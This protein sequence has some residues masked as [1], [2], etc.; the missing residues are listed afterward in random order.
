MI[1]IEDNCVI[2]IDGKIAFYFYGEAQSLSLYRDN[3][4]GPLIHIGY[5]KSL[6]ELMDFLNKIDNCVCKAFDK[7]RQAATME[8]STQ[9]QVTK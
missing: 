5:F 1:T 7:W 9:G 2:L 4:T 6:E 8:L 3:P